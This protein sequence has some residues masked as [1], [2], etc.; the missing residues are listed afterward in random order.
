MPETQTASKTT[1][2]LVDIL[3]G[4]F[5][6]ALRS[7]SFLAAGK[8]ILSLKK[9]DPVSWGKLIEENAV[10]YRD[11]AA[12]KCDDVVITHGELNEW[13]NR[14]ANHLLAQGLRKG[15]VAAVFMENR[16]DLLMIYCALAKIGAIAS[17]INTN[18]RGKSLE[19]SFNHA[20]G[21]VIIV[22]EEV[23][24]YFA[25]VKSG[26]KINEVNGLYFVPDKGAAAAPEGMLD[27]KKAARE[28]AT[29]NPTTTGQV[30]GRDAMAYVFTSGTTGG[31]PKAAVVIHQRLVA[32][33][34]AFGRLLQHTTPDDTV[35]L[36]LPFFHTNALSVG[37][38]CAIIGG[39]SVA[40]RRKFSASA[41][42]SDVHKFHATNF[43]Y[44]GELC[45][46]LL[47]TPPAPQEKGHSLKK[48]IGNG[49]RPEI[50]NEF[51]TRFGITH[52]YEFY[53]AAESAFIFNNLLNADRTI[54]VCLQ[55]HA[56][57]KYDVDEDKPIRDANGFLQKVAPG[58]PG[59]A[60]FKLS[61]HNTFAGY[62]DKAASERK[63]LR[64][65]FEK[66]DVWFNS[67]DLLRTI[68][69]GHAQFV[70]RVGDTFRWKGEN[71]S[72]TEVEA[73]ANTFPGVKMSTAY[74]VQIQEM[75]GRA[76]MI[77]IVADSAPENFD[78]R[79]LTAHFN[80]CLPA[81]AVPKFLRLQQEFDSTDTL[82]IK[83]SDL[84]K[85]GFDPALVKDALYVLLP[86]APAYVPLTTAIH[87]EILAGKY[88]L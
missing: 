1:V 6:L 34:Y 85:Q 58:E 64:D 66:G 41:F 7:R 23:A 31:L 25:E 88:K 36:P 59:L 30:L 11:H 15:E 12:I 2:T 61:E 37:W 18:Q 52:V 80:R 26:L 28:A 5:S 87:A 38:P 39:A 70:D 69:Y 65:V 32:A 56:L 81:Y 51:K 17:M 19:H 74:G 40:I 76:G 72:T 84:K 73:M 24:P 10:K 42:W 8:K 44:I 60:I 35:Y 82:K 47:N 21:K 62:T 86:D 3:P 53:G 9:D 77:S 20:P 57:V 68:G 16:P 48:A 55:P 78:F 49:L 46:Y 33:S 45:R 71:V 67:G 75:E 4:L 50:W 13:A 63:L 22:G 83:K 14:Y 29:D 27:L 79:G 54:G 43:I